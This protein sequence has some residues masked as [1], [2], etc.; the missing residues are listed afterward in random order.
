MVPATTSSPVIIA[1][2]ANGST[3]AIGLRAVNAVGPGAGSQT[4]VTATPLAAP[5]APMAFEATP[6]I[7]ALGGDGQISVEF[8]PAPDPVG[9]PITN[10]QYSLN[11]GVSWIAFDPP[12]TSSPATITGLT[13]GVGYNIQLRGV[14]SVGPGIVSTSA[15]AT[16]MVAPNAPTNLSATTNATQATVAFTPPSNT[17]GAAITNYEY[18]FDDGITWTAFKR[19]IIGSPATF[20]GLTRETT[21]VARLRAVNAAGSGIASL[22]VTFSFGSPNS[23][24]KKNKT[25][26]LNM[27]VG[28]A[29]RGLQS[30]MTSNR[31]LMLGARARFI[32]QNKKPDAGNVALNTDISVANMSFHKSRKKTN[33]LAFVTTKNERP[34]ACIKLFG[35]GDPDFDISGSAQLRRGVL[36]TSGQFIDQN[37]SEGGSERRLVFGDF[38]VQHD[39]KSGSTISTFNG[40]LLLEKTVNQKTV[41]GSFLGIETAN[42]NIAGEFTGGRTSWGPSLGGYVVHEISPGLYADAIMSFYRGNKSIDVSNGVL[43]LRSNYNTWAATYRASLSGVIERRS[44]E[45]WPELSLSHGTN[46]IDSIGYN[47]NAYGLVGGGTLDAGSIDIT[48]LMLRPE[49]RIPIDG[50]AL[51]DYMGLAT[52]APRLMCEEITTNAPTLYAKNRSCGRGAEYG[53][54]SQSDDG[55][56]EF[57]SKVIIDNIGD[58]TRT[59]ISINFNYQF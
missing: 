13:N 30:L 55:L 16:P 26:I 18:S 50:L 48:K 45:I 17:G 36:S 8:I 12:I 42:S 51:T 14:N 57:R 43:D 40:K 9:A 35:C 53:I 7:D 21:Y 28:D 38:D 15:Q 10:Y 11:G 49:I 3:Y 52:F 37:S 4:V 29:T 46:S 39:S 20:T 6:D 23:S 34:V 2:L 41:L 33:Q 58:S 47:A 54:V 31:K 24:F 22:A 25:K 59:G 19:A 27:V 5:A 1:G 32:R 44:F 56:T